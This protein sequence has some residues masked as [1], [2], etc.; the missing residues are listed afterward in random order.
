M[1]E[2]QSQ[3]YGKSVS[4]EKEL[5]D[6]KND[7]L[8]NQ[9]LNLSGK[10]KLNSKEMEILSEGVK[11]K[12]WSNEQVKLK[13]VPD[14]IAKLFLE[15][16]QIQIAPDDVVKVIASDIK[17]APYLTAMDDM[18]LR[19]Y[20]YKQNSKG[21]FDLIYPDWKNTHLIQQSIQDIKNLKNNDNEFYKYSLGWDKWD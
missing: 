21:S 7:K 3:Y 1:T 20:V 12:S 8:N 14:E 5:N 6:L 2:I 11:A 4:T 15:K 17:S 9:I 10:Q 16:S 19:M 13:V 18:K